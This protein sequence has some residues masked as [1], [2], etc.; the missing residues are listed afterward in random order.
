MNLWSDQETV[1]CLVQLELWASGRGSLTFWVLTG[2]SEISQEKSGSFQEG[3]TTVEWQRVA[4]SLQIAT[5]LEECYLKLWSTTSLADCLREIKS[6]IGSKRTETFMESW[7]CCD[8][9]APVASLLPW[10]WLGQ[11]L[12][13]STRAANPMWHEHRT[14]HLQEAHG[15]VHLD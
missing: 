11:F 13:C 6:E 4:H 3:D 5:N 14:C 1:T 7:P 9:K 10:I 15:R 8:R 12:Y 2:K